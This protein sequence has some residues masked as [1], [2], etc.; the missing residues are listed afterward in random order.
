LLPKSAQDVIGKPHK[1]SVAAVKNL[2]A[3]G[4]V[5]ADAWTFLMRGRW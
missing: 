3:E 4:F 2:E 5:F 1:D